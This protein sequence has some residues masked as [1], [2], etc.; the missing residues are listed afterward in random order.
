[1]RDQVTICPLEG[2]AVKLKEELYWKFPLL[3]KEGWPGPLNLRYLQ[4][5]SPRPGWL[6]FFLLSL[7]L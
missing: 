1:M 6:I 5:I 4:N 3:F 2:I 7:F